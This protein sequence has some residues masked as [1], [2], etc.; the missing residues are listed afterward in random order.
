MHLGLEIHNYSLF[1]QGKGG[2]NRFDIIPKKK[3]LLRYESP[4][5]ILVIHCG[6]NDIGKIPLLR[7]VQLC[8]LQLQN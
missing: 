5:E 2:I 4:P 6:A 3:L 8:N 7:F 1:W